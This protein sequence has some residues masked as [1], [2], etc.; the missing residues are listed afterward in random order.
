M[1]KWCLWS[2]RRMCP[3]NQASPLLPLASLKSRVRAVPCRAVPGAKGTPSRSA[4]VTVA[5][6]NFLSAL[7]N[8][9]NTCVHSRFSGIN[10]LS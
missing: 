3:S 1:G 2:P 6:G 7:L 10:G 8:K 4:A 5:Q 9:H